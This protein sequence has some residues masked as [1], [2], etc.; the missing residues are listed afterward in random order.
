MRP[1]FPYFGGKAKAA[2]SVLD[3]LGNVDLYVE[4]FAGSA[5]VFFA[6]PAA[7][8]EIVN[9]ADG[10]IC[11]FYRA[12]QSA[13]R[14]VQEAADWPNSEIDLHARHA[15]LLERREELTAR[16]LADPTFCDPLLAGWWWWG[17]SSW[18]GSGWG[19]R[20]GR[21][22]P[23]IDRSLKGSHRT[24]LEELE[25]ASRRLRNVTLLCGDFERAV[26]DAILARFERVGVFLDPPYSVETGRQAGLYA[27]D[28]SQEADVRAQTWALEHG[29]HARIVFAG[30]AAPILEAWE[31]TEWA[32]PNGMAAEV[33][34]NRK[35]ERL[36]YSPSCASVQ[37]GLFAEQL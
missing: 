13:P 27:L 4:P 20:P 18:F 15:Y 26:S 9:D 5:A 25:R 21:Q 29:A 33:N 3:A 12:V 6:R 34:D 10:Y 2:A 8:V 19:W 11:N 35:Q 30:Y 17:I 31:Q 23:H 28:S 14:A 1:L 37:R 24:P 36:W 22:R 7:G 16:L 32:A